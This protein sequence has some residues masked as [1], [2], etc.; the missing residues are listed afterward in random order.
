M[1]RP[2]ASQLERN[3]YG[4]LN[5]PIHLSVEHQQQVKS[6][7]QQAIAGPTG[8]SASYIES[9]G[10][11]FECIN[12]DIY[13][14]LMFRGKVKAIVVQERW[15]WK[16]TRKGYTRQS[17]EYFL[18][19]RDQGRLRVEEVDGRT[20][21]K[22]AKNATTLGDLVKHYLG[23]TVLKCKPA[24]VHIRKAYKVLAR[25]MDGS[26]ASVYDGSLYKVGVWRSER[27][28]EDHG[29]GFYCY[30]DSETALR[31]ARA[32]QT[33]AEEV[34]AGKAL[35]L[36]EVEIS[37]RKVWYHSGK[38]AASRLRVVSVISSVEPQAGPEPA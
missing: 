21:V 32:G 37:G 18:V 8:P 16:H 3:I 29:G 15:F 33:F 24:T 34:A 9:S 35:V 19:I 25:E 36:C 26:L 10:K 1:V 12:H 38:L 27:A 14:V 30:L 31:Q 4:A 7:L 28:E 23:K 2:T 20:C 5:L 17:K 13:D 6:L 11:E 22:R